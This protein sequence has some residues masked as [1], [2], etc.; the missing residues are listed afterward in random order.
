MGC[1]PSLTGFNS[2]QRECYFCW[3]NRY[4]LIARPAQKSLLS[5]IVGRNILPV[6]CYPYEKNAPNPCKTGARKKHKGYKHCLSHGKTHGSVTQRNRWEKKEEES[7][8]RL[9]IS[10]HFSYLEQ[11]F[12]NYTLSHEKKS[13]AS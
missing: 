7:S 5:P 13:Y 4:Q 12:V 10:S 9:S 3:G 6:C 1:T 8:Q 2:T 11:R